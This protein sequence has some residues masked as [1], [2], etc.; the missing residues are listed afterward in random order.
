[1]RIFVKVKPKAREEKIEKVDDTHFKVWVKEP[2]E[3][4]KANFAVIKVIAGYFNISLSD[5]LFIS[6]VSSRQKILEIN[7]HKL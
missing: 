4:G 5:V 6:G 2:P 1:M 3:N 7:W